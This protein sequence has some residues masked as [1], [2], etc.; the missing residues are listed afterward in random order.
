[1]LQN[2]FYGP[3]RIPFVL[4]WP[5]T[6]SMANAFDMYRPSSSAMTNTLF[7]I[8][9][10]SI[11]IR[12]LFVLILT[13]VITCVT[14]CLYNCTKNMSNYQWYVVFFLNSQW[15]RVYVQNTFNCF[16]KLT[17][18]WHF[19]YILS[20]SFTP[21]LMLGILTLIYGVHCLSIFSFL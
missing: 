7:G 1:M 21:F 10:L 14:K 9:C 16:G 19:I 15:Q 5:K 11:D 18:S 3:E 8:Y 13:F 4:P 6:W 12:H 17:V 2:E 20:V